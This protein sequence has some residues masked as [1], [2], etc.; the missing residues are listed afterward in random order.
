[1]FKTACHKYAS[2]T[3]A[4]YAKGVTEAFMVVPPIELEQSTVRDPTPDTDNSRGP[5][6]KAFFQ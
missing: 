5:F 1:M 3:Q 2:N 6:H 4:K